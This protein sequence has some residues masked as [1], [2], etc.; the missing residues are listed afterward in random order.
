MSQP[1]EPQS[2]PFCCGNFEF[3]TPL[4]NAANSGLVLWDASSCC[5][6]I[7]IVTD[8]KAQEI[9]FVT[10]PSQQDAE[11]KLVG[12]ICTAHVRVT[13]QLNTHHNTRWLLWYFAHTCVSLG[14]NAPILVQCYQLGGEGYGRLH[15][16]PITC[17]RVVICVCKNIAIKR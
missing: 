16:N 10:S 5:H 13:L 11:E 3:S 14:R 1:R 7:G 9:I 8:E 12:H 6:C 4:P 2:K 15:T 17:Y